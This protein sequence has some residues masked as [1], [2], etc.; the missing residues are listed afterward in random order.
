V[1]ASL[2]AAL[3]KSD[4]GALTLLGQTTQQQLLIDGNQI[5]EWQVQRAQD[6]I[7]STQQS[8][9]LAQQR[10]N[11]NSSQDFTNAA[12]ILGTTLHAAAGIIKV[13]AAATT[14]VGAVAAVLPNFTFGAAGFGGSPV[15]TVNDGGVHAAEAGHL[16]GLGLIGHRRPHRRCGRGGKHHW[17]VGAPQG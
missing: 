12:E 5:L 6:D 17:H 11:F 2:Q 8:Y 14:T 9:N 10:Y 16:A 3:E 1:G 15:A 7:D 13:I 4:S